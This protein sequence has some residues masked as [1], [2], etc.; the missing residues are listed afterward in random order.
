MDNTLKLILLH[1]RHGAKFEDTKQALS[2]LF[3]VPVGDLDKSEEVGKVCS[4]E[5]PN[6][7][8][9]CKDCKKYKIDKH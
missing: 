3:S 1:H 5:K 4:C 6:L 8:P 9:F 7:K 2:D